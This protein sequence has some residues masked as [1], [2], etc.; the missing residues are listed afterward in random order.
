[1]AAQSL[2]FQE[3]QFDVVD[4]CGQPWLKA[5]D[6][7]RALG[8]AREDSV[9]RIYDRNAYEFTDAMSLTV[10]LTVKGFGNGNNQK[11]VRVFSLRGAHLLAMLARTSVAKVFRKWVLNILDS[12]VTITPQTTPDTRTPL[13]DAVSMLVGK[14]HL[15]YPE[16]YSI[17]HQRFG[18]EHINQLT[19]DQIP[20]A[21]EYVHRLVLDGEWLPAQQ[22]L[23]LQQRG[24]V[25][26]DEEADWLRTMFKRQDMAMD[27][28]GRRQEP[29]RLMHSPMLGWAYDSVAHIKLYQNKW[30]RLRSHCEAIKHAGALGPTCA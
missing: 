11:E 7:A 2:V 6:I 14:R 8:Y 1:M 4:R 20:Q 3:T 26:T 13:R 15:M 22:S 24:Y 12:L 16:A 9:S 28:L 21:V 30:S 5:A 23:D 18:V 10:K 25:V 19:A 17:V 27:V 29:L